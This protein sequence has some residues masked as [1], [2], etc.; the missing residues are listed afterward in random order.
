MIAYFR[1]R[2]VL[3]FVEM[4]IYSSEGQT[5]NTPC[6][7]SDVISRLGCD[8]SSIL[9][10][11]LREMSSIT[12]TK[13]TLRVVTQ[14]HLVAFWIA[15]INVSMIENLF[16]GTLRDGKGSVRVLPGQ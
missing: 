11:T 4:Y 5:I 16:V 12:G 13:L 3:C 15:R 10:D 7:G 14:E 9:A 1:E 2:E 8:Q 6:Y